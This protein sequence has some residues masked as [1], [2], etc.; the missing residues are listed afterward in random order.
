MTYMAETGIPLVRPTGT[1]AP[2][3]CLSY[4]HA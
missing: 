1:D 2:T 4:F 3:A